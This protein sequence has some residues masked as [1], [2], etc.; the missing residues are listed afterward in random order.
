MPRLIVEV[1]QGICP[2][3]LLKY[4]VNLGKD[5]NHVTRFV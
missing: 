4:K 5:L 3:K 2:L 1:R